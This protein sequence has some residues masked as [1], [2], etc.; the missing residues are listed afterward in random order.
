MTTN[1]P[2]VLDSALIRPGRVDSKYL[3]DNCN[4]DQIKGLYEMFFSQAADLDQINKIKNDNY[5]PAHITSVFLRYRNHP[6]DALLHLD[7]VETKIQITP[8]IKS[9]KKEEK[10]ETK[11]EEKLEETSDTYKDKLVNDKSEKNKI[12]IIEIIKEISNNDLKK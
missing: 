7:D 3:F 2:E 4:K 10:I 6:K 12:N 8:I 11:K 5:S 9:E 1:H